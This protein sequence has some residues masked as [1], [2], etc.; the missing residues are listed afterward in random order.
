MMNG[1]NQPPVQSLLQAKRLQKSKVLR[2]YSIVL[3]KS[4]S[5]TFSK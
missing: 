3:Q 4:I 1:T 2:E 5:K